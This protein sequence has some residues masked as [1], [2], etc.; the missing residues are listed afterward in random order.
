MDG[1]RQIVLLQ[2]PSRHIVILKWEVI[3]ACKMESLK[4]RCSLKTT[5]SPG[6]RQPGF[7]TKSLGSTHSP[8]FW[9]LIGSRYQPLWRLGC[10]CLSYLHGSQADS[11]LV[12]QPHKP[13]CGRLFP[14][15]LKVF[16]KLS[17]SEAEHFLITTTAC[18]GSLSSHL[19]AETWIFSSSVIK[20]GPEGSLLSPSPHS[21]PAHFLF[22]PIGP[23]LWAPTTDST[24][25]I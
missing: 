17:S 19:H 16:P 10:H 11:F 8:V 21:L 22:P 1:A 20:A 14:C 9:C 23:K 15:L 3:D 6:A 5:V 25:Q 2:G 13:G 24:A 12:P 18:I 4:M 7:N